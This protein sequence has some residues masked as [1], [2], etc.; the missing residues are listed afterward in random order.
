MRKAPSHTPDLYWAV[1][2]A[3]L[4]ELTEWYQKKD[5]KTSLSNVAYRPY[6]AKVT[7]HAPAR[8]QSI[9]S[10]RKSN[11]LEAS[12][13]DSSKAQRR[14]PSRNRS[15][16]EPTHLPQQPTPHTRAT[17]RALRP[18]TSHGHTHQSPHRSL[19]TATKHQD[20]PPPRPHTTAEDPP[21]RRGPAA[22]TP[23]LAPG[24][25]APASPRRA[26]REARPPG[27]LRR[28]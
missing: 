15:S 11:T 3:T 22:A 18:L 1:D 24:P 9:S 8:W 16:Q 28:T 5:L 26:R 14:A 20:A 17:T 21:G 7:E 12:Q 25:A 13:R 2:M 10:A 27:E 6:T 4:E 19:R 23:C